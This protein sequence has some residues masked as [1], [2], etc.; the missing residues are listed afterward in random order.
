MSAARVACASSLLVLVA[1]SPASRLEDGFGTPTI[2]CGAARPSADGVGCEPVL[3]DSDCDA[4]TMAVLGSAE[5]QPVG[6]HGCPAGFVTEAFGCVPVVPSGSCP[7]A[8]MGVLGQ[9]A[10]QPVGD[11]SAAFPPAAATLFVDASLDGGALDAT[12]FA[13]VGAA[14][15]AAAPGAT[16]AIADGQYP[17]EHLTPAADVH[18]VGRC[19]EKVVLTGTF[20]SEGVLMNGPHTVTV[21]GVT[22]RKFSVGAKAL[23]GGTV[24][25]ESVI[26]E[27][28]AQSAVHAQGAHSKLSATGSALRG[29]FALNGSSAS[30]AGAVVLD[31]AE[32]TL[33]GCDVAGNQELGIL[34]AAASATATLTGTL[35]RD[36]V[37]GTSRTGAALFGEQKGSFVLTGSALVRNAGGGGYLGGARLSATDTAIV[38]TLIDTPGTSVSALGDPLSD[39][40]TRA[41]LTRIAVLRPKPKGAGEFGRGLWLQDAHLDVTDGLVDGAKDVGVMV[42]GARASGS[43]THVTVRGVMPSPEGLFAEGVVLYEGTLA[44]VDTF[45]RGSQGVGLAVSAGA[46]TFS[47]G[48]LIGNSVAIHAQ[49]GT[50][51]VAVDTA[52]S[53]APRFELDVSASTIVML[54]TVRFGTGIQPLP[55]AV[56]AYGR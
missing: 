49:Q 20:A 22:L 51:E 34:S 50:Q 25:L 23:N 15:A 3:P 55:S 4:G 12:H 28:S 24:V 10:C 5:C 38:V 36:T 27:A 47:G 8:T 19:A 41:V 17:G 43:L 13:S 48:G 16:I 42:Y 21:T 29:S 7:G 26:V 14:V 46:A 30:T 33:T 11:C 45:I 44:L 2:D 39:D 53:A 52:S 32:L 35:V 37:A 6:W 18:L 31:G 56:S 1:C 54:N 40:R 9:A